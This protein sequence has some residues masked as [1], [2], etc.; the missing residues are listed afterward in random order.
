[1]RPPDPQKERSIRRKA[2]EMVARQGLD[3]FS[4]QRL[5]RAARMS[6]S[7][8]YVYFQDRDDLLFQL[9]KS[10]MTLLTAQ[11]VEGFDPEMSLAEGLKVQWRNRIRYSLQYPQ[12]SDFLE[13]IRYSPY[14]ARFTA[15]MSLEHFVPMRRFV[16]AAIERG[17]LMRMPIEV[18]WSF[19][20]APLYQLIKF[21]RTG[22]GFPHKPPGSPP[23]APFV[24]TDEMLDLAVGIVVR[25]LRPDPAQTMQSQL[26]R[27][28]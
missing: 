22:F 5:A 4:M 9:F 16:M 26:S 25:G 14:H 28:S 15:R 21:H 2:I 8:L 23:R 3:G 1:M 7:T 17:E 20:F 24:L 27:L 19:A 12:E 11:L 18:Y 6:P 13:H 10:E